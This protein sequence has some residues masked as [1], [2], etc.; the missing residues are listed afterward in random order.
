MAAA[1]SRVGFLRQENTFRD[2]STVCTTS[3]TL[4]PSGERD[5]VRGAGFGKSAAN[6]LPFNIIVCKAR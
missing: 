1:T 3:F 5:G 4:A 6:T 2:Q